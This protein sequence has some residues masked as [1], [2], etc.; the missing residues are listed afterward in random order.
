MA[1]LTGSLGQQIAEVR[2]AA[3]STGGATP[4]VGNGTGSAS[5]AIATLT[6]V[7]SKTTYIAGFIVTG[8]GAT[9]ASV[10]TVVISGLLGGSYTTYMTVVA[11]ATT[12]CVPL[13]IE[14]ATPLAASAV[15][16]NIVVTASSFGAGNTSS[17]VSA[18]GYN[19]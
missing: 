15:N 14:F 16:T 1:D 2:I 3:S 19:L 12:S 11:G 18:H 5:T 7:A 6:A 4:V 10:V 13:V 8:L 17:A 9:A